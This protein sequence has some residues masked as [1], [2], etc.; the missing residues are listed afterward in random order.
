MSCHWKG[1]TMIDT[2]PTM[3]VVDDELN[4]LKSLRRLFFD[5]DYKVLT[6]ESGAEGR[7]MFKKHLIHLVIS[8][9]RMPDMDGVEFLTKVKEDYPDT[10]RMILSGYA[11][12]AAVVSAIND[13]HVY[14]FIAKPWNDQELLTTIMRAFE[15]YDLQRENLRLYTQLQSRNKDLEALAQSL[16]DKVVERT[17]DLEIKNRALIIAQNILNLLPVGVIG[18]DAE[19]MVVYMNEA[20]ES[21][22][23]NSGLSLGQSARELV[24]NEVLQTMMKAIEQQKTLHTA[25]PKDKGVYVV[26]TPLPGKV[27]VIGLFYSLIR[28]GRSEGLGLYEKTKAGSV[29]G[30]PA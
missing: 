30:Q 27:G 25:L 18:I 14:K 7:E 12:V 16:E 4:V 6:A 20:A 13:G 8:D 28:K 2:R 15:Q 19:E 23:N 29:D 21:Y 24:N 1:F 22:L 17:R 10:I 9:F 26:C 11:D 5:S 3:L